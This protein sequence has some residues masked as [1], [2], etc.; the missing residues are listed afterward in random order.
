MVNVKSTGKDGLYPAHLYL[1]QVK[2]SIGAR[3]SFEA[4]Q[5]VRVNNNE[6]IMLLIC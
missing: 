5:Q 3:D 4:C 6:S 2:Q 1:K